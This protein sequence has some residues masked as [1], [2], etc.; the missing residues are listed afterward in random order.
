MLLIGFVAVFVLV[1]L[2]PFAS[3]AGGRQQSRAALHVFV[4]GAGETVASEEAAHLA[5]IQTRCCKTLLIWGIVAVAFLMPAYVSSAN[6]YQC[7]KV[8]SLTS[9]LIALYPVLCRVFISL[10][11]YILI[12]CALQS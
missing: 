11:P 8:P 12:S 4:H 9:A 2:A 1:A 3:G 5:E 6:F 10:Y 7:G